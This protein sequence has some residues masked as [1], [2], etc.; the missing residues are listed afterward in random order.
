M[1]FTNRPSDELIGLLK[2]RAMQILMSHKQ[3]SVNSLKLW[4]CLSVKV[5]W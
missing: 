5:F 2:S 4:N 1:S 3:L